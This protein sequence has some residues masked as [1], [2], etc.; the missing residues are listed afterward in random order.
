MFAIALVITVVAAIGAARRRDDPPVSE[1]TEK[2]P[3]VNDFVG[4][5]KIINIQQAA[6]VAGNALHQLRAPVG[7]FVGREQEIENLISALLRNTRASITGI[8]GMGGVG[9]TELVLMVAD[10]LSN[11]YP[12][13]QFFINLQG[14][15]ENARSPQEVM[16]ICIRAFRGPEVKLPEDLDQLSQIYRSELSGKRVLLLLDNAADGKQV[17][18][19]LPPAGCALL[20]TSRQAIALPAMTSFTL[21]PLT[22]REARELLL[23]IAPHSMSAVDEICKLCG[24]LPLA[25]R[26]AG[27]LLRVTLDLTPSDYAT[28]LKDERNRLERIGSEGVEINVEASF[29]LNYA[30]LAPE[31]ARVFRSLA[32]FPGTFDAA[33]A[34]IVCVDEDHVQLS[35]LVRRSLVLFDTNTKRY[36]LHDLARLFANAKLSADERAPASKGHAAHYMVVLSVAGDLYQEGG[37][38]LVRGLELFDLEWGNIQAGHTWITAQGVEADKDLAQLGMAYPHI[39]YFLLELRLHPR[40]RIHWLEIALTAA[41]RLDAR[42]IEG[43]ALGNL[44][45]AYAE[46]GE[47]KRAIQYH[48]QDLTIERELGD[49]RGESNALGNL[50]LGFAALGETKRAIQFYEQQLTIVRDIGNSRGEGNALGNLGIAYAVLGE[51]KRAIQFYKQ[52]LNIVRKI[53]D[54]RG[55]G[56]ALHNLGAV[57]ENQGKAQRAIEFYEQAQVINR[58]LADRRGEGDAL[59]GIGLALAQL[60]KRAQAIQHAEQALGIYEQIEVPHA[61]NVRAQLALWRGE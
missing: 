19:L 26:A 32:V 28:Q 56:R 52:Q 14:T 11:E 17:H 42:A 58:E 53:G 13:A 12:D 37:E 41:R 51:T 59:W 18:P 5:D 8:S 54:R 40:E 6:S 29:N 60:G 45:I 3:V 33:A 49:R 50:G 61:S 20:I 44:G 27:S 2:S 1:T 55:E 36:R 48:E 23:E 4:R 24:Y 35:D 21:N 31:A 16:A 25:I 15:D 39:A 38:A 43:Y 10:R 7:D 47:T 30:R 22:E 9:K 46:L 57:Y 34:E